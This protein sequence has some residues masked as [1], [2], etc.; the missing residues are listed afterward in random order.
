MG[1]TNAAAQDAALEALLAYLNSGDEAQAARCRLVK[2]HAMPMQRA[3]ML[4][5]VHPK[6]KCSGIVAC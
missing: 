5:L 1:D 3:S 2:S 4:G 6:V